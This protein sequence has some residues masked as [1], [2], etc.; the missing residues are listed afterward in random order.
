M[1]ID[2]ATLKKTISMAFK[3]LPEEIGCDDCWEQLDRFV[4]LKLAGKSPAEAMP[5]IQQHLDRCKNCRE[6][7]ELLLEAVRTLS[8]SVE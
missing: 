6:E 7:F 8:E 5:L 2:A 3:T 1:E 4:D